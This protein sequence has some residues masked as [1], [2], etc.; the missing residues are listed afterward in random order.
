MSKESCCNQQSMESMI[1]K[2]Q[3]ISKVHPHMPK[4][5][6]VSLPLPFTNSGFLKFNRKTQ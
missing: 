3:E 5:I 6:V 4:P 1:K 2:F